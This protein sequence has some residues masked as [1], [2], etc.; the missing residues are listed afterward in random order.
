MVLSAF[1]LNKQN[2]PLAGTWI[3]LGNSSFSNGVYQWRWVFKSNKKLKRYE[4]GKLYKE[5]TYN[6]TRT[7]KHCG[8]DM[9]KRLKIYP[10][11][12]ILILTNTK[13]HEKQC[14]LVYK[15]NKNLLIWSSY[16]A[17]AYVDT[18]EKVK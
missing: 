10:K 18:L 15:I 14:N 12:Y 2:N 17:P 16:R 6:L 9:S 4:N 1:M 7:P 3:G 5:W 8:V 11:N 13:T